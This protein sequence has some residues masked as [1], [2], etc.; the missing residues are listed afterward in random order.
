MI[1]QICSK[2]QKFDEQVPANDRACKGLDISFMTANLVTMRSTLRLN[3]YF[4]VKHIC[5]N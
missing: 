1:F 4:Q 3:I 2:M 5:Q